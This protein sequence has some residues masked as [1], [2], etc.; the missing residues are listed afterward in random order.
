MKSCCRIFIV[1]IALG[2]S[3]IPHSAMAW[4]RA[5][6]EDAEIVQRSQLIVVGA[7]KEG[8]LQY[9]PHPHPP[10]EGGS[11]EHHATLVVREVLKGKNEQREL[12]I[13][14][15]YGLEPLVDGHSRHDGCEMSCIVPAGATPGIITIMDEGNSAVSLIP[16]LEDAREDNIWMLRR[17]VGDR[18]SE[19]GNG[20]YGIVDPEDVQRLEFKDYL[21]CYLSPRPEQAV[22]EQIHKQPVVT[23]RAMR[24]LNHKEIQWILSEPDSALRVEKLLPYYLARVRWGITSEAENGIVA[25]GDVA[26]PYLLNLLNTAG[27]STIREESIR[28]LGKVRYKDC[29]DPLIDLLK[30]RDKFWA[31]QDLAKGW[32]NQ[33]VE[34]NL[35]RWRREYYGDVHYSVVAL[36]EIGDPKAREAIQQTR[37]R[38]SKINF[39]KPQIVEACDLAL[40]HFDAKSANP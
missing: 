35:T 25:A 22:R 16:L 31:Q 6:Y 7:L 37:D 2:A 17:L 23:E 8:S 13:V 12:P 30:L 3:L 10:G 33:D 40:K 38:W 14:I 1:L 39:D 28:M 29:V 5:P 27:N 11:W 26:G 21:L 32:W 19:L 24:Y 9:V 36:D 4:M 15:H 18:G 34:S 20:D